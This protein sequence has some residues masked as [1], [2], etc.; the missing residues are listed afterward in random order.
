MAISYANAAP[1]LNLIESG[2]N[3]ALARLLREAA[4]FAAPLA[5]T[6]TADGLTTGL[7]STEMLGRKG[8][9]TSASA[10][11]IVMLPAAG[12]EFV[13]RSVEFWVG[14]NGCEIRCD[15]T[16][17]TINGLDCKTTNEA[18]V[19]ATHRIRATLVAAETWLLEGDTELGARVTIV[20]DAVA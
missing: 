18:A 20:P 17:C 3:R 12:A 15:G 1:L 9:V 11:N 16:A 8:T 2:D 19:P 10:D 7:I 5:I 14:A 6:A 13:G 4:E